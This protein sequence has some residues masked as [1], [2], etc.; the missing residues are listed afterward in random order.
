MEIGA[1]G[2]IHWP[3]FVDL[4]VNTSYTGAMTECEAELESDTKSPTTGSIESE[5]ASH[6][7]ETYCKSVG[8]KAFN[9]DPLPGWFEFSRDPSKQ[10]QANAWM[11]VA[12]EAA[13]TMASYPHVAITWQERLQR[14]LDDTTSKVAKLSKFIDGPKFKTLS[15]N[16]QRLQRRQLSIMAS[17]ADVLHQRI[18]DLSHGVPVPETAGAESLPAEIVDTDAPTQRRMSVASYVAGCPE[19]HS[20]MKQLNLDLD[21]SGGEK[22]N[23]ITTIA[24]WYRDVSTPVKS[25]L[26]EARRQALDLCYQIEKLGCSTGLT[27]ASVMASDLRRLLASISFDPKPAE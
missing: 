1:S 13:A 3:F 4:P 23:Q 18:A 16:Q 12:I 21:V 8:G 26:C 27:T 14:E 19:L 6:L 24:E 22:W 25:G 11:D 20:L 10:K 15:E 9:G 2:E 17:L 7:Y 5:I